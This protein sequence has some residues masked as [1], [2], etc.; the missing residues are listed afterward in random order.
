MNK[1]IIV[2]LI[3]ALTIS[4]TLSFNTSQMFLEKINNHKSFIKKETM[5]ELQ[6]SSF[7]VYNEDENPFK[8]WS[9]E[10]IKGLM[11]AKMLFPEDSYVDY[12]GVNGLSSF[13]TEEENKKNFKSLQTLENNNIL[14][15]ENRFLRNNDKLQD[16]PISFD[17]R[18]QWPSC[19]HE[20]RNQG[21]CGSC[22]AFALTE[23]LEDRFCILSNGKIDNI[24][25]PQ[26]LVSCDGF[27]YACNGG[28]IYLS[29]LYVYFYGVV[30]EKCK[31]YTS[32][33]GQ[34]PPCYNNCTNSSTAFVKYNTSAYPIVLRS[35]DDIKRE[36]MTNG[37]VEAGFMVYMD[38]MYYKSGVYTRTSNQLLGGHAV[39]L[40]GFGKDSVTGKEFWI[41]ANSWG[42]YWGE[43][44][45]FKI[46]I[47]ECQ[48]E[49]NVMV[50]LPKL[51]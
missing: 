15:E 21:N 23:A 4:S 17:A 45:Y 39:K 19:I 35:V 20:I 28:N 14:T 32:G 49:Q 9:V 1:S 10:E 3:F 29:W 30:T 27:N 8:S 48:L 22:W 42:K 31:P 25:S 26:H 34:V 36:I 24:L 37:P 6:N 46:A 2:T 16:F 38:F 12:N 41:V 50:G 43:N 11:G 5:L 33:I 13:K 51:T 44:G 47:G 18:V 40:V 7:E